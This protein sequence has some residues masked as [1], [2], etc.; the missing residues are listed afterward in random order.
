MSPPF[1]QFYVADYLADTSQLTT[2]QH[3]AYLLLLFA[4]WRSGGDLD[5]DDTKLARITRL[6]TTRWNKIKPDLLPLLILENGRRTQ[7]RLR[8]E[9][10]KA[11]EKSQKRC[12]AG[13][14]GGNAKA[15]KDNETRVANA[16][17]LPWHLLEPEPDSESDQ[18]KKVS[19]PPPASRSSVQQ[20]LI[21]TPLAP[22][23]AKR[24]TSMPDGFPDDH[25]ERYAIDYWPQNGRRD[26]CGRVDEIAAGFRDHHLGRGT[27]SKDWN[28]SWRTWCRNAMKF[29][30]REG[31]AKSNS[32]ASKF[33]R[34][35]DKRNGGGL[36]AGGG[37]GNGGSADSSNAFPDRDD[38]LRIGHT[39]DQ[40]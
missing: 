12:E 31:H 27:N 14:A 6:S 20:S 21:E 26:L 2:E 24:G 32:F 36:F 19:N 1:L 28:A 17:V 30:R 7:K 13:R 11:K 39:P 22:P 18:E 38:V 29:E 9:L 35:V 8:A 16:T 23:K 4:M 3:G 33:A 10:K 5:P 15:L 25:A 37:D 40:G 34:V